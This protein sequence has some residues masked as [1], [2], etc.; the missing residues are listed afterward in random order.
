MTS[1]RPAGPKLS[2]RARDGCLRH[3]SSSHLGAQA[4][5]SVS[6][7]AIE[8][9][10]VIPTSAANTV[11]GDGLREFFD[12]KVIKVPTVRPLAP[13]RA[14]G[15]RAATAQIVF[16]GETHTYPQAGWANTMHPAYDQPWAVVV[17]AIENANPAGSVSWAC[18]LFDYG[19]WSR[20][21]PHGEA[22]KVLVHNAA[23]RRSALLALDSDLA[24][25][26]GTE[27]EAIG[28][29][30]QT[31]GQRIGYAPDALLL[32]LN[33]A[34]VYWAVIERF[35][36]GA[37]LGMS[38]AVRWSWPRRILYIA[39]SPLIV[40]VLL[41]RVVPAVQR[42]PLRSLPLGTWPM[43]VVNAAAKT[44]GEVV[45]YLGFQLPSADARLVDTENSQGGLPGAAG[46]SE[47]ALLPVRV[48]VIGCGT[49]A[50]YAHLQTLQRLNCAT[51]ATA[52]D[53]DPDARARAAPLVHGPLHSTAAGV[54][55][56]DVDAVLISAPPALHAELAIAAARA[57]KHVYVEK[58]LATSAR[59]AHAVADVVAQSGIVGVVG[60]N[61]RHHPT[62]QRARALLA[63][64][65][66]GP[67]QA[68]Q[69][70]FCEPLTHEDMPRWKV[71]R[72]SGGGAVLDFA[73]HHVD[74]LRWF[75]E[76]EIAT[77]AADIQSTRTRT[78][79]QRWHSRC[80]AAFMCR[81]TSAFGPAP[82]TFWSS[83]A[84]GEHCGWIA[85][86]QRWRSTWPGGM[87]TACGGCAACRARQLR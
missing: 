56:S 5:G 1:I 61:Y 63:D 74:L 36:A 86:G 42:Q 32:H 41:A 28:P 16:V 55:E 39:A 71:R 69:T 25:M 83:P 76:D 53:V 34:T 77:V 6:P 4:A 29:Y 15:I 8:P 80:G 40:V 68:V 12:P 60:F 20:G 79:T 3:D 14:E 23:Y 49:V 27:E 47:R 2:G 10:I 45:G 59:D 11:P 85:T 67:V 87:G 62:H 58:P 26:L 38:R 65:R 24:R 48:G 64:G 75:L 52:A 30:L 19:I 35:C 54:L 17:P 66:I 37:V 82:P 57:G 43:L 46:V 72:G 13:A 78:I 84:N 7:Q 18:Y 73:S 81:C 22:T 44:A 31:T 51:L 50:Y 70:M 21:R 33:V 9:V